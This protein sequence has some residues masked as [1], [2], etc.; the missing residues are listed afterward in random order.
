MTVVTASVHSPLVDGGKTFDVRAVISVR[1]FAHVVA[2][3]IKTNGEERTLSAELH[4]SPETGHAAFHLGNQFRISALRDGAFHMGA[5][6]ISRGHTHHGFT[7]NGVFAHRDGITQLLHLLDGHRSR[8]EFRPA[9]FR[10]LVQITTNLSQI[11][12]QFFNFLLK[13]LIHSNELLFGR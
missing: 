3:H 5:K 8:A 10:M 11:R 12:D 1:A 4:I 9:G 13:I 7:A 6:C 2:V